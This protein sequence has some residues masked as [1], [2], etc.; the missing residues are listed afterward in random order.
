MRQLACGECH[1]TRRLVTAV[2]LNGEIG[3]V[4]RQCFERLESVRRKRRYQRHMEALRNGRRQTT[5]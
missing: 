1:E 3:K 5:A 4:C 2:L